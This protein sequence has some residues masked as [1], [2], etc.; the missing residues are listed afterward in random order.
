MAGSVADTAAGDQSPAPAPHLI[1]FGA[2]ACSDPDGGQN[3][4]QP[5]LMILLLTS[6]ASLAVRGCHVTQIW[7][8]PELCLLV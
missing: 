1:L 2:S 3:G 6:L 4:F 5:I 8:E 7:P